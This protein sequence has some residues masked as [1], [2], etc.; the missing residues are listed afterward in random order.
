MSFQ[1][2]QDSNCFVSI[3]THDL[4][5]FIVP[6]FLKRK[7][8][9]RKVKRPV[10][11]TRGSHPW[12]LAP[13]STFFTVNT[14][15]PVWPVSTQMCLLMREQVAGRD[16]LEQMGPRVKRLSGRLAC[17]GIIPIT[18]LIYSFKNTHTA[19]SA[20]QAGLGRTNRQWAKQSTRHLPAARCHQWYTDNNVYES[21]AESRTCQPQQQSGC[22]N[23]DT[24]GNKDQNPGSTAGRGWGSR[25]VSCI[26]ILLYP[27]WSQEPLCRRWFCALLQ[28]FLGHR[29]CVWSPTD[30]GWAAVRDRAVK[31]ANIP[32]SILCQAEE[33]GNTQACMAVSSQKDILSFQFLVCVKYP[34]APLPTMQWNLT[35]PEEFCPST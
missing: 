23:L 35:R 30:Q 15:S 21:T 33:S 25:Q 1:A 34:A 26:F 28:L 3:T 9:P 4:R 14:M 8:K 31:E 13:A 7:L 5:T 6:I 22:P 29:D 10:S 16:R 12:D 27:W 24:L 11:G 32:G 17:R 18:V 2:F 19:L 20:F